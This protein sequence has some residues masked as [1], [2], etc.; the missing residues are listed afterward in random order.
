[1]L[2]FFSRTELFITYDEDNLDR[3]VSTLQRH[4][5]DYVV[6][7]TKVKS[8]FE[9]LVGDQ[10][11]YDIAYKVYVPIHALEEGLKLVNQ[12]LFEEE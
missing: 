6:K 12:A 7:T 4:G 1:M 3:V 5:I 8:K 11:P 10:H 9:D 2:S